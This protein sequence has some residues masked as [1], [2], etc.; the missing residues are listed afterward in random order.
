VAIRTSA[1]KEIDAL[2]DDLSS[3]RA[4]VRETALARLTVI[5]SRSVVHLTHLADD[6]NTAVST[7]LAA[8]RALEAIGDARAIDV[9]RRGLDSTNKTIGIAAAGVLQRFLAGRRGAEVTDALA[10]KALD[11]H[12]QDAV[13]LAALVALE[14]LGASALQPL[15]PALARDASSSVRAHAASFDRGHNPDVASGNGAAFLDDPEKLRR[16]L[17]I[18]KTGLSPPQLQDT[19]EQIRKREESASDAQRG[20]WTRARGAAHV[21]LA[22]RGSRIAMYDL[23]ESLEKATTPLPVEFMAALSLSGDATCLESIATAHARAAEHQW[24]REHLADAFHA[25]VTREKLTGRHAVMKKVQKRWPQ[26]LRS[27]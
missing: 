1:A 23:R 13:R 17:S 12:A 18:S 4:V 14:D 10:A 21:A 11:P 22:K 8:L 5:G 2:I 27:S 3:D 26:I 20:A 24:W 9:A 6:E 7:R 19:I 15:W 16:E 25:I